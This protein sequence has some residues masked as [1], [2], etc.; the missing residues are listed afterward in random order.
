MKLSTLINYLESMKDL[1]FVLENGTVVPKHFHVTELGLSSKHFID[2]GGTVRKEEKI[3]FQLWYSSDTDHR[4]SPTKLLKIIETSKNN[5]LLNDLEVEVEYQESTV[6][7]YNLDFEEGQF[8]LKYTKTACL[9]EDQCLTPLKP[10]VKFTN[11]K[12]INSG[13]QGG[14]GCC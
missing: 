6:G 2:C 8:I 13:C 4:L 14:S 7:K 11:I 9:A 12:A 1:K 3:I 10:E 5:L